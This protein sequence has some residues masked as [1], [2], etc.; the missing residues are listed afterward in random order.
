M[1]KKLP[2]FTTQFSDWYNEVVYK[3]ELADQAPVRGCMVVR[4]Y[5][6]AIWENMT[7]ILDT[8]FKEHGV[9]N[10]SFPLLIP[11]SFL[12]KEAEHVEGFAPELA[13]VTHAG[14]KKLEE[15]LVV[16]PTSETIIHSM[17]ARW[18]HS[19]R[20]LP[21]KVNQWCS[22]VRWEKRSRPFLR[23][24]EFWWQEGHTAHETAEEALQ[25]T[26]TMH[27]LYRDFMQDYLAIPIVAEEKPEHERFAGA[28]ATFTLEAF[29]PD[30]K[31]LQMGT[32]HAISQSFAKAFDMMFQ[33]REGKQAYPHLTSW[34]VTTRMIG[35]LIM[36][37]GD[38]K[39]IVLP[40]KIAP[41]QV[42]IVPIFRK[43]SKE[44][45]MNA[46]EKIAEQ[47]KKT[48]RV[49]ID[50]DETGT[51]GAKFY[52]WELKGVPLRIEIG[53]RDV[54]QEQAVLADRL[55]ISKESC[56]LLDLPGKVE[57]TLTIIQSELYERALKRRSEQWVKTD[58]RLD[59][60]GPE[61]SDGGKFYQVGWSGD[62]STAD[63]LKKYH[64]TIR[65]ILKEKTAEKC[66]HT[67]KKSKFDILI[68]KAY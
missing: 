50:R 46:A 48:V 34:G 54:T 29:M 25:M 36:S 47:L 6:H 44:L 42:V 30:A 40:P 56:S 19:W 59:E 33:D 12:Q 27:H 61:L 60:L 41:I 17:F 37:H 63:D 16:R 9:Q 49:H 68:A 66:F 39:G 10:A 22:V 53:P 4:P 67:G 43:D 21:L 51:P 45:V 52:K 32:S 20:D 5:G 1:A 65:C 15:P 58:K 26:K 57:K 35:A 2:D 24:T 23:T 31:A 62:L 7:T 8:Q 18:I 64:G 55:G 14:G 38:N 13:V 28:T 3:A 11:Q